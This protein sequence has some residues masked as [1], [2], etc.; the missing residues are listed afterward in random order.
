VKNLKLI[1][2]GGLSN[3]EAHSPEIM[4]EL[5]RLAEAG[6]IRPVVGEVF[7]LSE[8]ARAHRLIE[9]RKSIGKMVLTP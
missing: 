4:E 1:G 3:A 2:W 7:P 6:S 5:A 9:E 8:A